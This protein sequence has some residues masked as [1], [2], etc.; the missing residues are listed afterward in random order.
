MERLK[1]HHASFRNA[2]Q[3]IFWTC[4]T[5]HNFQVHLILSLIAIFLGILLQL[6]QIEMLVIIMAIVLGLSAE[7]INTAL[8]EMTDLITI[9]WR[10]EAKIAKDVSAGMVLVV[11]IG[12]FLIGLNIFL[13]KLISL[14][15]F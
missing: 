14:L 15:F 2:V 5:Q 9:E 4:T 13:P 7:M 6:S 3:G 12:T 10:K 1:K 11:A 8:E